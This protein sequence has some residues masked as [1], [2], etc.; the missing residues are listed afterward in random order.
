MSDKGG[1]YKDVSVDTFIVICKDSTEHSDVR[2][3]FM[4]SWPP[5]PL[6]SEWG[7]PGPQPNEITKGKFFG[8]P[9]CPGLDLL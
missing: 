6:T 2:S 7:T 1:L 4:Q 9:F 5:D 8:G 3:H